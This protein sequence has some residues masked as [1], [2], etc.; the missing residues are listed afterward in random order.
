MYFTYTY[1][2]ISLC[3]L[4]LSVSLF[5][6]LCH[7]VSFFSFYVVL[8]QLH[9]FTWACTQTS[10]TTVI[11]HLVDI[12][13]TFIIVVAFSLLFQKAFGYFKFPYYEFLVDLF[14]KRSQCCQRL[15]P[16]FTWHP[17]VSAGVTLSKRTS[18]SLG[19]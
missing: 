1:I 19:G 17:A 16:L 11:L 6:P 13:S 3:A 8:L 15:T 7:C 18:H 5:P 10:V 12:K 9:T 14:I 4:S 2:E